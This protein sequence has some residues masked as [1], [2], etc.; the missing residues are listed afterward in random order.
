M[1]LSCRVVGCP[2]LSIRG[3]D[4]KHKAPIRGHYLQ[5][6][7]RL[8]P[9]RESYTCNGQ[10]W[11]PAARRGEQPIAQCII[12]LLTIPGHSRPFHSKRPFEAILRLLRISAFLWVIHVH[13]GG[14]FLE[15]LL[16]VLF[17]P[18]CTSRLS[19]P[20]PR[21]SSSLSRLRALHV[22]LPV[23]LSHSR[24]FPIPLTAC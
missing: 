5:A 21:S 1:P 4:A 12:P 22:V 18:R 9:F 6:I 14:H 19:D 7:V 11:T 10:K 8:G 16:P 13:S 17:C 23:H 15:R 2:F 3:E 20:I 24:P